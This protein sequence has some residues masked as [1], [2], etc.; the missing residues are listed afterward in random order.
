MATTYDLSASRT[1]F[2]PV[3]LVLSL[4]ASCRAA[5]RESHERRRIRAGLSDLS[6]MALQDIGISRGE[7]DY[8]AANRD[9]DPR[10]V[11]SAGCP[12]IQ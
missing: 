3:R 5:L 7:I 8:V 10:G 6:D 4:L 12:T 1:T 2:A 9:V 11:R